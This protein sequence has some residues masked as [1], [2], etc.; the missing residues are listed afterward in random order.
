MPTTPRR[1]SGRASQCS[2]SARL[3]PSIARTRHCISKVAPR[4]R[5]RCREGLSRD[6]DG[7]LEG[8]E[9]LAY[10]EACGYP[11]HFCAYIEIQ[12]QSD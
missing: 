11:T 1:F 3:Q 10:E 6:L 2:S 8:L 12:D 9:K 5:A 7:L 4:S